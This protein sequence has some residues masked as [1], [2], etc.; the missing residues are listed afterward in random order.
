MASAADPF[1]PSFRN[2]LK[3]V[4]R[5]TLRPRG[6]SV[7]ILN[8]SARRRRIATSGIDV[9]GY[10]PYSPGDDVRR[11]DW[12][13]YARSRELHVIQR[14]EDEHR[15]LSVLV[16]TSPSMRAGERR[17]AA[18]RL[19]ALL[20]ALGLC[21]LDIVVIRTSPRRAAVFHGGMP[22]V[23]GMLDWLQNEVD[24]EDESG[25]ADLIA[26]ALRPGP[27]SL[28]GSVAWISDFAPPAAFEP[29]LK[30]LVSAGRGRRPTVVLQPEL[31]QDRVPD[32]DGYVELEDPE[33]GEIVRLRVDRRLRDE[34]AQELARLAKAQRSLFRSV[35]VR[36]SRF[37]VP[38]V[39]DAD[40][41]SP[42]EWLGWL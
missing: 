41:W 19:A 18:L 29:A 22:A 10:R 13:V 31:P 8:R 42:G 27:L 17:T 9:S 14:E 37:A 32:V 2:M 7:Q 26:S 12:N 21:R 39:L 40:L 35:G 24:N 23:P 34:V 4:L 28:H 16:D 36:S 11:V 33:T 20:G 15:G 5:R 30:Q 1:G 6:R 3:Q 25:P 38:T